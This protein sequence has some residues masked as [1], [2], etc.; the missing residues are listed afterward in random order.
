ML[1]KLVSRVSSISPTFCAASSSSPP[2]RFRQ[3]RCF[4]L[5]A[6][7]RGRHVQSVDH[8]SHVSKRVEKNTELDGIEEAGDEEEA[9]QNVGE[10]EETRDTSLNS[11]VDVIHGEERLQIQIQVLLERVHFSSFL[12]GGCDS[13]KGDEGNS[14]TE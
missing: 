4:S 3:V 2:L 13:L 9:A 8:V 14:G 12:N 11:I 6:Y 1:F 10:M 7:L 5:R